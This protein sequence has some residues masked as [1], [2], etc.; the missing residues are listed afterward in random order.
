MRWWVALG[1]RR[2]DRALVRVLL[3]VAP[4]RS[5]GHGRDRRTP[6]RPYRAVDLDRLAHAVT[7]LLV[8]CFDDLAGLS[9]G[10][11]DVEP[12]CPSTT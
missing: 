8:E 3:A 2:L 9:L 1:A 11:E 5:A 4:L 10:V 6:S 12:S 7:A